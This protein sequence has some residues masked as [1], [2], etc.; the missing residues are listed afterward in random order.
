MHT[1]AKHTFC[2]RDCNEAFD[3]QDELDSHND[4]QNQLSGRFCE[5]FFRTFSARTAHTDAVHPYHC[6]EC[7]KYFTKWGHLNE[8]ELGHH[9]LKCLPCDKVFRT[10]YAL[11]QHALSP[12][13][14]FQ[15]Q[16]CR[17]GYLF[18]ATLKRHIA[19]HHTWTCDLCQEMCEGPGHLEMHKKL[20]H[21]N[22]KFSECS[23]WEAFHSPRQDTID[24]SFSPFIEKDVNSKSLQYLHSITCHI[25]CWKLS[26]EELR[27]EDYNQGFRYKKDVISIPGSNNHRI[28]CPKC[29]KCFKNVFELF[30]HASDHMSLA[31]KYE[32]G[33]QI[34]S[35]NEDATYKL[36]LKCLESGCHQ[37][38]RILNAARHHYHNLN[39]VKCGECDG[40]FDQG[41][42]PQLQAHR[43][44]MHTLRPIFGCVQCTQTFPLS[45]DVAAHYAAE[46]AFICEA[47][48]GTYFINSA[49]RERHFATCAFSPLMQRR[50]AV[51]VPQS[52][53]VPLAQFHEEPLCLAQPLIQKYEKSPIKRINAAQERARK[54]LTEAN[55]RP[56]AAFSCQKCSPLVEIRVAFNTVV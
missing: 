39:M 55:A 7:R 38:S 23:E 53:A 54:I 18:E 5:R 20:E 43:A 45:D 32:L 42:D 25:S 6:Y 34:H 10:P 52:S 40:C 37:Q 26:F 11:E 29:S 8:H 33:P 13:H 30:Q 56:Q 2:C 16:K 36:Q 41:E 31:E 14:P 12:A 28:Q 44:K 50:T 47:C 4:S 24:V 49:T 35:D 1:A 21:G 48:L 15:C 3:D 19:D 17:R 22:L 46:H 27:L 51:R 9:N